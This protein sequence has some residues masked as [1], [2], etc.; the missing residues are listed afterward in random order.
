VQKRGTPA[1]P[2]QEELSLVFL[3]GDRLL[4]LKLQSP[5][6]LPQGFPVFHELRVDGNTSHRA[7]LDA[8]GFVKM[9]DTFSAFMGVDL[10][11]LRAQIN[12]LIRTLRLTHIAIDA[13]VGDDQSHGLPPAGLSKVVRLNIMA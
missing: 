8:L 7:H 6:L 13:L 12:G 11:D 9:A 1:K 2:D 3:M 5:V 4:H 10:I